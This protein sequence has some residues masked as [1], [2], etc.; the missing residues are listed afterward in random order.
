L[1]IVV[2]I[3]ARWVELL[4]DSVIRALVL[5]YSGVECNCGGEEEREKLKVE[6]ERDI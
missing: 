4:K 1:S 6:E 2:R 3:T 5:G